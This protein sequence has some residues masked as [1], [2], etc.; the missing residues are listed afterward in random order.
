MSGFGSAAKDGEGL[1]VAVEAKS[2]NG[3]FFKMTIKAPHSLGGRHPELE[4]LAKERLRRGSVTLHIQLRITDPAALVSINEDVVR[5]YQE[6]FRQLG[7]AEQLIP[8]LP[9]V[10]EQSSNGQLD[11][12]QWQLVAETVGDALDHL[13]GMRAREGELLRAAI[14]QQLQQLSE[15]AAAVRKRSPEVVTAHHERMRERVAALLAG[16]LPAD[17]PQLMREIALLADRADVTEELDRLDAH[18]V[19]AR[20]L[21]GEGDEVGR[22]LEFLGQEM[23]REANTIGSK[24]IDVQIGRHVVELKAIVE[25]IKEQVANIA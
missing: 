15:E 6:R 20:L 24:N 25:K 1:H 5:A 10:L 22:R 17:D 19:Q 13:E 8:S 12:A 3:R 16:D 4:M 7:L 18:I 11:D 21:L 2:I 9:G 14:E 23:L